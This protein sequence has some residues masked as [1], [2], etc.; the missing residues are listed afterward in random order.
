MRDVEEGALKLRV[1]F[2]ALQTVHEGTRRLRAAEATQADKD[3]FNQMAEIVRE[4]VEA[5]FADDLAEDVE[6]I[7]ISDGDLAESRALAEINKDTLQRIIGYFRQIRNV[8]EEPLEKLL[9][10][11]DQSLPEAVARVERYKKVA[12]K[13]AA[14]WDGIKNLINGLIG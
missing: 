11:I 9:T 13:R 12:K 5:E 8:L 7:E 3:T 4:V 1:L 10:R 6:M 2:P 14:V